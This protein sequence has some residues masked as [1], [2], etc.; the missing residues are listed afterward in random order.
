MIRVIYK[1]SLLMSMTENDILRKIVINQKQEITVKQTFV[2]RELLDEILKWFKDNRV[3][4]LTG[5][6]RCGKSTL[7]KEIMQNL[8][9]WCYVNFEDERFLNFKAQ[10]F[11]MLNEILIEQY[12]NV[13][14]YFF[15]EIQNIE[16]F[17][18]FVR[19]LQDEGKKVI[20]TGSNVSNFSIFCIS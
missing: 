5:I 7:L 1:Y 20:I 8:S 11:E 18:T 4:I 14:I 6:R 16:K 17:E 2:K 9:N 19:R 3:I 12:G 10:D 13:N 15:D